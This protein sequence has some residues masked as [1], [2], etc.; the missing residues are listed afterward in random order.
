MI[1][2]D[3]CVISEVGR[4]TPDPVVLA[5]FSSLSEDDVHLSVLSVGE[6]QRGID[7]LDPG[8]RQERLQRWLDGLVAG[9]A[10]RILPVDELAARRWGSIGAAAQRMGRSR[11][12]VDALI[13]ATA[14]RHGLAV[15]TRNV[16]DFEGTGAV[17]VNP[18]VAVR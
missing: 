15:A 14:L 13:A 10:D 17:I 9:F 11:P 4:S 2:L 3:T 8:A 12:P 18:W 6:I 16:G 7:L 1:L 5:W